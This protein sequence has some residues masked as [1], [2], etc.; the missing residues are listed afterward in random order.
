[1]T[2]AWLSLMV[3]TRSAVSLLYGFCAFDNHLVVSYLPGTDGSRLRQVPR[4]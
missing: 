4:V 2:C 3:A 1:M